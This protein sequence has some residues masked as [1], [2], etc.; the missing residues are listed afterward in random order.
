MD[1]YVRVDWPE[2]QK[3][4]NEEGVELGANGMHVFVPEELYNEKSKDERMIKWLHYLIE[5]AYKTDL[6]WDISKDDTLAW[7]EK[8]KEQKPVEYLDA[9]KINDIMSQLTNLSFSDKLPLGSDEYK[10]IDRI[11]RAVHSLY[12][13]AIEQ[14]PV[15]SGGMSDEGDR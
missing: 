8:Q 6:A 14:K 7:L 12:G 4:A 10:Q 5:I 2:S 11:T 15:V 3:W 13:C 9:K 1:K